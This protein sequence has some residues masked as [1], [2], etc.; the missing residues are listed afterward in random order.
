MHVHST[1]SERNNQDMLL[2]CSCH[3]YNTIQCAGLSG[4]DL[5]QGEDVVLDESMTCITVGFTK[6]LAKYRDNLQSIASSSIID[7]KVKNSLLALNNPVVLLGMA[8]QN[9]TTKLSV[10]HE[11][12]VSMV[13][14]N[15]NEINSCFAKCQNGECISKLLNKKKIP[16]T[17][18]ID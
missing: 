2:W 9:A 13:H 7:K 16:K 18:S 8:T 1:R 3:I 15:F 14:L 17:R 5:S 6:H 4:T 11:D 10:I 12:T